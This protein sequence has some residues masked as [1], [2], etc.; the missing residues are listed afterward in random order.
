MP[1]F[2]RGEDSVNTGGY[3][4]CCPLCPHSR[5]HYSSLLPLV[6]VWLNYNSFRQGILFTKTSLCQV[7]VTYDLYIMPF[8]WLDSSVNMDFAL[9]K[10]ESFRMLFWFVILLFLV[11]SFTHINNQRQSKAYLNKLVSCLVRTLF[12]TENVKFPQFSLQNLNLNHMLCLEGHQ[13]SPRNVRQG[14]L[15]TCQKTAAVHG[16]LGVSY[17]ILASVTEPSLYTV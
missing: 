11:S 2:I 17:L 14:T 16:S 3:P 8:I 6:L 13:P 5:C 15:C 1:M 9:W 10:E 7:R 4:S 12:K